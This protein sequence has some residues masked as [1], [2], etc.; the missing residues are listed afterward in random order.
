M[1]AMPKNDGNFGGKGDSGV[2]GSWLMLRSLSFFLKQYKIY[3][4]TS[5]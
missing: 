1:H 4:V 2:Q 5:C 3:S